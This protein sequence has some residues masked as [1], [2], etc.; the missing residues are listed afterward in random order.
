MQSYRWPKHHCIGD[1]W[2]S[3]STKPMICCFN[4][5]CSQKNP[6]C[7][8]RLVLHAMKFC[9]SCG[10]ELIFLSDRYRPIKRLGEG[11]FAITYLAY[12]PYGHRG[13]SRYALGDKKG[14][15]EDYQSAAKLYQKQGRDSDYKHA[16][17]AITKLKS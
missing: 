5:H 8:V 12:E 4:P 7:P 13:N 9:S 15:I 10:T 1:N 17:E 16:I 2:K 11:V 14:A 6:P 3:R